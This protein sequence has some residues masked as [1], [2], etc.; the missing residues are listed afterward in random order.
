MVTGRRRV[1]KTYL[2]NEVYKEHMVFQFTGTQDGETENQLLKFHEK[3]LQ[4][5][6][7][8][9]YISL[10]NNWFEAFGLLK[11]HLTSLRKN[12]H[13][14]VLFFDEFPWIDQPKSKFLSEFSYWWNDWASKQ[15]ILVVIS[16]SATAWMIKKIIQNRGGLHNR[17]TRRI[18]LEPFSLAET[19]Q[20]VHTIN[21]NIGDYDILQLYMCMGGIPHYLN[22]IRQGE[23]PAQSIHRLCFTK[24][25]M[26]QNEFNNVYASLFD[27]Y[28]DHAAVVRALASKWSGL[29]R[30]EIL[31][32]TKLP[33]GGSLNRTLDDLEAS[34]FI[35]SLQ[36]L[37][38]K[39]KG[40]LYR[41]ADEYSRFYVHFIEGHTYNMKN[42]MSFQSS[43]KTYTAWQGYAFENICIKHQNAIKKALGISGINAGINSYYVPTTKSSKGF[44]IDMIIDRADNVLNLCEIKY[45]NKPFKVDASFS[46]KLRF[47][48][49]SF[50]EISK[51][52]KSIFNTLITTFGVD[53][54]S[55]PSSDI[56][57]YLD[58]TCL[59]DQPHL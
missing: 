4:F 8:S 2:I 22:Q 5:S 13:K 50:Q 18:H 11:L 30:N 24:T 49:A 34:N 52:K 45:Y 43:S 57:S 33:D 36:P 16:G 10:P 19:K 32:L 51:S 26:L 40:T 55:Y 15:N 17:V 14:M 58:M 12:K 6:K 54:D 35:M 31:K 46:E 42:W 59:F 44:Q 56:Q 39:K 9:I 7:K 29:S 53:T 25:G 41:L 37:Y 27:N 28:Q 47:R 21:K 38:N 3:L 23:S 20:F 1:G 48:A